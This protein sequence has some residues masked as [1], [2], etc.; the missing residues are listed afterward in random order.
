MPQVFQNTSMFAVPRSRVQ[1][2]KKSEKQQILH[3]GDPPPEKPQDDRQHFLEHGKSRSGT[4]PV[5]YPTG[6]Y[7]F[8]DRIH[9]LGNTGLGGGLHAAIAPV[10]TRIIDRVAY[11][12][13]NVRKYVSTL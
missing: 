13:V 7:W 4:R 10:S 9:T 6:Q 11:N 5:S 1:D 2:G 3:G 12:G 8:D